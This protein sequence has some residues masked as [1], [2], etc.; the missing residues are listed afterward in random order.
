MSQ[1]QPFNPL[2][3]EHLGRS[4]ADA[5][6]SR[7]R[8]RLNALDPFAGAG[9][10]AIYYDGDF[11][12]YAHLAEFNLH[13]EIG[14]P[15]YVGKAIP[16]GGR[17]GD[18]ITN[19]AG[20]SLFRRLSEHATSI[21]QADN[22]RIDDFSCRYLVVED[23]WIPLGESLLIGRFRPLWNILVDGF[24]NHDPGA[25]RY[26]GMKPM[27]DTIHPGRLWASRLQ[28]N[29]RTADEIFELVGQSLGGA[30][31]D[32]LAPEDQQKEADSDAD[33]A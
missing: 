26:T 18:R 16:S 29:R 2:E 10:Y 4:V 28:P 33:N 1:D 27:W 14:I 17:K 12:S 21:T 3:Y 22:L 7:P 31:V 6:L 30:A 11:P 15:I 19:N 32:T 20:Q 23:I 13:D 5:M 24:G 25:R 9:V 8:I